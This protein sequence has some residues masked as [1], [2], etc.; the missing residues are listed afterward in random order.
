MCDPPAVWVQVS[1]PELSVEYVFSAAV[2]RVN[3]TVK[4]FVSFGANV[5][6]EGVT[7]AVTPLMPETDE[8]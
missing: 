8:M 7:T 2:V 6:G 1:C 4:L 3:A 5:S